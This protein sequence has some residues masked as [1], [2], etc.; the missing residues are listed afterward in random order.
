MKILLQILAITCVVAVYMLA[1]LL[2]DDYIANGRQM[3]FW[4]IIK[5]IYIVLFAI[6]AWLFARAA[7]A[8]RPRRNR[9]RKYHIFDTRKFKYY[10]PHTDIFHIST[11]IFYEVVRIGP[12]VLAYKKTY[13]KWS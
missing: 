13:P 3:Y 12:Y 2:A 11:T 10:N 7:D 9:V 6:A 4:E 5:A 1:A 8:Y